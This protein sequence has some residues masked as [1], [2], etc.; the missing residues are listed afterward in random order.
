MQIQSM[1]WDGAKLTSSDKAID[2]SFVLYFGPNAII[3]APQFQQALRAAAPDAEIIGCTTGTCASEAAMHDDAAL[4]VA[5]KLERSRTRIASAP[6]SVASSRMA[7]MAI[8]RT[9][10]AP[11]L[12]G[13]IVLCD[14]LNVEGEEL[15]AGLRAVLGANTPISGGLASDGADFARTLVGANALPQQNIVA[16]LGFY[17]SA[18]SMSQ[19]CAHGWDNFGPPRR[20]TKAEGAVLFELDGKPALDLYEH[21]LGDCAAELPASALRFPLL[22]SDPSNP[23]QEVIR[24]VLNVDR[25]ARSLSFAAAIPEGWT[26]RLMRGA[27]DNL[28]DGAGAAAREVSVGV[29]EGAP[30]LALLVSCVGRRVVLGEHTEDELEAVARALPPSLRQIGFYSHGEISSR[31]NEVFCGLHNQT[32]T[33]VALQEAA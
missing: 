32:M 25:A 5:V 8:A 31:P 30:G 16:A 28:A 26:A 21:Y 33:I 18:I 3:E 1:R 19:G 15:L 24:T 4:A 9:L 11:D 17:G 20:I 7:G 29:R 13:V 6:V 2:A 27:F 23:T 14:S 10:A 12:S 22:I